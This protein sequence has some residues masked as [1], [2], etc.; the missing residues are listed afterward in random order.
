MFFSRLHGETKAERAASDAGQLA[1]DRG[2][3]F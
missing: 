3:T 2:I 1:D